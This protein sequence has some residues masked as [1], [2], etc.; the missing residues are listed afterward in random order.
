[1]CNGVGRRFVLEQKVDDSKLSLLSGLM[2]TRV[3][4]LYTQTARYNTY[5][6]RHTSIVIRGRVNPYP[7][8]K[9]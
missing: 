8:V 6:Y 2:K 4:E 3:T 9:I 5:I 1:M 7:R